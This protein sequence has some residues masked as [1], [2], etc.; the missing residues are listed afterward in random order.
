[1]YSL[2]GARMYKEASQFSELECGYLLN[3][4][5]KEEQRWQ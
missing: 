2:I 4:V 5:L 3:P 1:M